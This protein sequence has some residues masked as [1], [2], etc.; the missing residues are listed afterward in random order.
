MRY[1]NFPLQIMEEEELR[2]RVALPQDYVGRPCVENGRFSFKHTGREVESRSVARVLYKG[3]TTRV[4]R[5]TFADAGFVPADDGATF[6]I[7][8][9]NP[10]SVEFMQSLSPGQVIAHLAG[11]Y[12]MVRKDNLADT[13]ERAGRRNSLFTEIVPKSFSLPAGLACFRA[14]ARQHRGFYILKAAR[15]ARGEGVKLISSD[16][17]FKVKQAV[18]QEYIPNP[19]LIDGRKFDLRLYVCVT[20]VEP[21]I[22]YLFDDGLGR[23]A[24]HPYQ[25]PSSSNKAQKTVHLTNYSVNKTDGESIE[26]YKWSFQEILAYLDQNYRGQP[27]RMWTEVCHSGEHKDC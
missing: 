26:E 10:Q 7:C 2:R 13:L 22:A 21:L 24:T 23:F 19:L 4:V 9:G 12:D 16:E 15:A 8:W 1:F 6:D 20:S 25:K 5:R 11:Q 18:V 14:Y 3:P 27:V 17:D